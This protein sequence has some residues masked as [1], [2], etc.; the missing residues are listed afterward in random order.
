M[1]FDGKLVRNNILTDLKQSIIRLKRLP[2]LGVLWVGNNP[3]SKKY[4]TIKQKF[5]NKIG[6][7]V[8]VIH[9]NDTQLSSDQILSII[10][11]FNLSSSCS[12]CSSC[13]RGD[14]L[15]V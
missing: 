14:N 5:A 7:K 9:I 15:F 11:E 6:I 2:V 13:L 1:K 10:N 4:V 8:K 12:S 3:I